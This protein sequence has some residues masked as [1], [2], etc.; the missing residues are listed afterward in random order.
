MDILEVIGTFRS[1]KLQE[2]V[3]Y[4]ENFLKG[5]FKGIQLKSKDPLLKGFASFLQLASDDGAYQGQM[6]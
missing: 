5:R 6:H 2:D 3:I 4:R 1:I